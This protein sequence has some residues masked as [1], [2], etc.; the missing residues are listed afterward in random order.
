MFSSCTIKASF[1]NAIAVAVLLVVV[2]DCV[3][4]QPAQSL[5][6]IKTPSLNQSG[7]GEKPNAIRLAA[8][9][10]QEEGT[11]P[12]EDLDPDIGANKVQAFE[13]VEDLDDPDDFDPDA[14]FNP[15]ADDLMG[16][17]EN[18]LDL[19]PKSTPMTTWN[20]KPMSSISASLRRVDGTS[21]ADQSWQLTSRGSMPHANTG[22]LFAWAAPDIRYKPLYFEDVALERYGQTRGVFRQ[23]FAS[24]FHFL[25][26]ATFLPYY[27]L[28][29]PVNSCDGPLGYCRPG[30]R[31]NCAQSKHFFGNPFQGQRRR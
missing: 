10:Q 3:A 29:D 2:N 24:G 18:D 22:K 19:Q 26:S 20:L 15:D 11:S 7:Y 1:L 17:D 6:V 12:R 14:D 5:F 9:G 13:P 27:S 16:E 30:V 4:Q 31:V 28:Y 8:A 25:K 23:P 21:P